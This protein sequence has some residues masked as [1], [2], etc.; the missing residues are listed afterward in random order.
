MA[1]ERNHT[2][3]VQLLAISDD[4]PTDITDLEKEFVLLSNEIKYQEECIE[5]LKER[6]DARQKRI[7][8]AW[9]KSA[10]TQ[11]KRE[12]VTMYVRSQ[13]WAG[14]KG[15]MGD[16]EAKGA[17]IKALRSNDDT[18]F[19]VKP[20]YNTLT[21][22]AFMREWDKDDND[23]PIVPDHLKDVLKVTEKVSIQTRSS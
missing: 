16:E 9:E 14:H 23:E 20:G 2:H 8:A 6:R 12:G 13:L 5:K 4:I 22:S 15:A 18:A 1:E 21:L 7:L 11:I 19:L 10:T 17:L 3:C